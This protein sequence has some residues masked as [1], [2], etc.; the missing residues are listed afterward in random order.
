VLVRAP[1]APIEEA[2]PPGGEALD[3]GLLA[4]I[5]VASPALAARLDSAGGPGE[6]AR[7]LR[8]VTAYRLRRS[9]RP[10]PAGLLAGVATAR[11]GQ[12]VTAVLGRSRAVLRP[13][14]GWLAAVTRTIARDLPH[15]SAVLVRASPQ[16]TRRGGHLTLVGTSAP[17]VRETALVAA[18]LAIAGVPLPYPALLA[19]LAAL[20][21]RASGAVLARAVCDLIAAGLVETDLE[22]LPGSADPLG[23][24]LDR[25]GTHPVAPPLRQL[26]A[27]LRR[28]PAQPAALTDLARRMRSVRHAER[29]IRADLITGPPLTLP[30]TVAREVEAAAAVVAACAAPVVDRHPLA[31][32]HRAFLARF[33]SGRAVGLLTTVDP[34][35]GIG[36]PSW[37]GPVPRPPNPERDRILLEL[38]TR[39][40]PE[41][42][43][44]RNLV[45]ALT[46]VPGPRRWPDSWEL[47]AL[48]LA[49][50]VRAL[51]AGD[52][53]LAV[54]PQGGASPVGASAG[55]FARLHAVPAPPTRCHDVEVVPRA[56]A[57]DGTAA[58]LAAT[59]WA[60]ATIAPGRIVDSATG[61]TLADLAVVAD[62]DRLHLVG[63]AGK[64]VLPRCYSAVHAGRLP[65]L[66]RLLIALGDWHCGWSPAGSGWAWDWG[67]ADSLPYLPRIRTGR[68]LLAPARWAVPAAVRAPGPGQA[69]ALDRWRAERGLPSRVAVVVGDRWLPLD[70]A[71]PVHRDILGRELRHPAALITE[72][73]GGIEAYE[74]Q[75]WLHGP[76]G[77]YV[78][79]LVCGLTAEP[80]SHESAP[81]ARPAPGPGAGPAH[82]P[83][84]ERPGGDCLYARIEVPV[85]CQP[86]A[87]AR[88]ADQ[89][90][91]P[92][93][94]RSATH[95]CYVRAGDQ[96]GPAHLRLRAHGPAAAL[97]G[98]L[99]PALR[100]WVAALDA[101]NLAG[102]LTLL[103]YHPES[104]RYGGMARVGLVERLFAADS[105]C[106]LATLHEAGG[107]IPD[108]DR[109]AVLGAHT[110]TALVDALIQPGAPAAERGPA[111]GLSTSDRLRA[112]ARCREL[113]SELR[114]AVL[115]PAVHRT[116]SAVADQAKQLA[117]LRL[118]DSTGNSD[119]DRLLADLLHLH[120]NRLFGPD[121]VTEYV[122]LGLTRNLIRQR[123]TGK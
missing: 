44:D 18:V 107:A 86:A 90:I 34:L 60:S 53:R 105:A 3:P 98:V 30:A 71:D 25:A 101:D 106:A 115:P 93:L 49:P 39:G 58:V 104:A 2:D 121:A 85:D 61:L 97:H 88:L 117:G 102:D 41:V 31:G 63:P 37:P 92:A 109:L 46:A 113:S 65:P 89:L 100:A 62:R 118:A 78:A 73:P 68:C 80:R 11:F 123:T 116:M 19:R 9:H 7:V 15:D 52:F 29:V 81:I 70:L 35:R 13:D 69:A 27:A 43:V 103:T 79:E 4:A 99:L 67:A 87:L 110:G 77:R 21:P 51:A 1:A 16:A 28:T 59:G 72:L 111:P 83:A 75:G 122:L 95:W 40:D 23:H 26:R 96:D 32:Y 54:S 82:R 8:A 120:V 24:I 14:E 17:L 48:L 6:R 66:V 5:T 20:V 112:A 22:P 42:V 119:P 108:P 47:H 64:P 76:G 12:P 57:G 55:R 10:A 94:A 33:G 38:A 50:D 45:D 74:Q 36:L 56:D 91:A 84:P 114:H